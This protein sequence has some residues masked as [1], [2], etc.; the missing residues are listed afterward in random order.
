MKPP[1]LNFKT[2]FPL[3]KMTAKEWVSDKAPRL[4]AALAYYTVFSIAPLL[5]IAI[6]IAGLIFA[7]AQQQVVSQMQ[8]LIGDKGAEAIKS[9]ITATQ[10]PAQSIT[11]TILGFATLIF[12]A[13]GVHSH[14]QCWRP[15]P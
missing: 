3:L 2:V 15:E 12:G 9:M 13:A 1:R 6:T 11:A 14:R 5:V 8:G 7:D 4:G 10:K